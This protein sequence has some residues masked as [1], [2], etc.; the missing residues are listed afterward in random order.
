M[1]KINKEWVKASLIRAARTVAQA[2]IAAIG[3]AVVMEEVVW[4]AVISNG[5]L[6][7]IISLLM[8]ISGLPEVGTDGELQIDVS[9]SDADTYRLNLNVEPEELKNKKIFK[10]TVDPNAKLSRD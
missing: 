10:L 9:S 3:T 4:L 6:A 5:V 7:G 1:T 8:S 2:A